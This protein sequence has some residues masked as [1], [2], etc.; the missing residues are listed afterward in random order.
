MDRHT[1]A[2]EGSVTYL[3]GK[4]PAIELR[5]KT[6]A[7]HSYHQSFHNLVAVNQII[8][9]NHL[10]IATFSLIYTLNSEQV[11]CTIQ[12]KTCPELKYQIELI[13]I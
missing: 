6:Q 7:F 4:K 1:N 12:L 10:T 2:Y 5:Q 13:K 9:K 3:W 8:G 11:F